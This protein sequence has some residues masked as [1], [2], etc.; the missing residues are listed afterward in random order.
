M[1]IAAAVLAAGGSTRLGAPKQ[2]LRL[3]GETL[4]HRAA[5][6]AIESGVDK[7][8]VVVGDSAEMVARELD[9][10]DLTVVRNDNWHS[11][12]SS[13]LRAAVHAA[14]GCDALLVMLCDQ[15]LVTAMDLRILLSAFKADGRSIAAASYGQS[16]GVP[17]IFD[18]SLFEELLTLTGDK[19]A[20]SVIL[21]DE[22]RVTAVTI[23][24]AA[25]DIDSPEDAIRI[26]ADRGA[27]PDRK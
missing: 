15:P 8:L 23:A 12:M 18:S 11:G 5:R 27:L 6:S 7:V 21:A 16:L 19:G 2:L 1:T 13:S 22:D 3:N 24:A 10:L 9:D 20:K 25:M 26:G 17:A 4:V 14:A